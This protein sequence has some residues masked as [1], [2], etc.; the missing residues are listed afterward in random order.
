[1][2]LTK[3]FFILLIVHKSKLIVAMLK[4]IQL[5]VQNAIFNIILN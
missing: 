5:H 3:F 1:M 4:M 2:V